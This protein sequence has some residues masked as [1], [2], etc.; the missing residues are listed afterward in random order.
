MICVIGGSLA[1]SLLLQ[2]AEEYVPVLAW[3][4]K[5]LHFTGYFLL[6]FLTIFAFER[7]RSGVY[8]AL[9]MIALG[10]ALEFAQMATPSRTADWHDALA[11]TL[12][13]LC[14]IAI[15]ALL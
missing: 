15:A 2:R 10:V 12:G 9:W 4:D 11:N 8:A 7:R 1:P 13:V 3:S 14:G 6:A 5:F